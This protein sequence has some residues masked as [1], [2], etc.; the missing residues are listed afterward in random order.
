LSSQEGSLVEMFEVR[1]REVPDQLVLTEQRHIYQPELSTWIGLAIGR[2]FSSAQ[3]FG[4]VSAP[5]FVVYYGEVSQDSDGPVEVCVPIAQSTGVPSDA[6]MRQE[7]A[8]REA[9]VRITRAQVEYPQILTAYD[10]VSQWLTSQD[11]SSSG[12][13]REVYFG[14][15]AAKPTDEWCDVAY[16]IE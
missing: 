14:D 2:L 5:L 13:P 3:R 12:A 1:Q 6:P 4:G 10:A 16:P 8:H 11:L 15:M 9:Y 7:Q